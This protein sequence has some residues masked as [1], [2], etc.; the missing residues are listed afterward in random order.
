MSDRSDNEVLRRAA[1]VIQSLEKRVHAVEY[2]RLEP[3]AIVG[4]G[5]RLPGGVIDMASLWTMLE[6]GVDAVGPIPPERFDIA[7]V[8]DEDPLAPGKTYAR[9]GAFIPGIEDFDP[10]FFGVSPREAIWIDP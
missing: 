1:V 10:A 2:A 9:H 3:I 6:G 7:E 4:A 5:C 8:Y